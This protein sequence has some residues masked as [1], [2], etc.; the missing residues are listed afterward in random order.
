QEMG[1]GYG[2]EHSM[3]D[4]SPDEYQDR[5]DIMSAMNSWSTSHSEFTNMGPVLNAWNMRGRSWLDETRVWRGNLSSFDTRLELRPLIRRDLSG[6]LAADLPGGYLIEFRAR[7]SWDQAI[8]RPA[9]LVHTFAGNRSFLM[10]STS[11]QWDIIQGDAFQAGD[12]SRLQDPYLRIDVETVEATRAT[13]HIQHRAAER[14][15]LGVFYRGEGDWLVW[16][17]YSNNRWHAEEVFNDRH[18]YPTKMGAGPDLFGG[19]EAAPAVISRWAGNSLAV[20]FRGEDNRLHWKAHQGGRWHTDAPVDGGGILTSDP[21]LAQE[22][23]DDLGVFYRS[24]DNWLAW[25]S[26][27]EGQWYGEEIFNE[28]HDYRTRLTSAPVAVS[29]WVGHRFAVFFR[30]EDDRLHWKAHLGGR[31]HSDGLLEGGGILTSNPAVVRLGSNNL[32]IFYRTEG[33]WLA[34]RAYSAG[35]LHGEEVFDERHTSPTRMR[36]APTVLAGWVGHR[37]AVFFRGEDDRLYWK[38]HLG[39]RW[40]SNACVEGGERLRSQPS[41]VAFATA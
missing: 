1:H 21:A 26:Y 38:A 19:T 41:A 32:G 5:W 22:G 20:F 14:N 28:R 35:Q 34:W 33:D 31:W 8:P 10:K 18:I 27:S 37:F 9:I 12:S 25:R 6:W 36:S 11:N 7:E 4:G 3:A 16:R 24:V 17:A 30:G 23:R 29:N 15:N 39:G 13:L 2:L 40:H